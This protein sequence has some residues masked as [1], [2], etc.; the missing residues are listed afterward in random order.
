MKQDALY[1]PYIH[2]DVD[3]LK[4]SLLLFDRVAR[5]I[6]PQ[7]DSGPND[8]IRIAEFQE[9]GLLT[10]PNLEAERVLEAQR[11][12]AGKINA[13]SHDLAFRARYGVDAARMVRTDPLGFQIHRGKTMWE[14]QEALNKNG[15]AWIPDTYEAY[16]IHG[17]YIEVHPRVG[18]AVMSTIAIACALADGLHIVG[19]ARSGALHKTLLEKDLEHVYDAWLTE[20]APAP[21]AQVREEDVFDFLIGV[22]CDLTEV[23]PKALQALDREPLQD[24]MDQLREVIQRFPP[25]D[26]GS[27][28]DQVVSDAVSD[29]L[30]KWKGE[31]K[32]LGHYWKT[33]FGGGAGSPVTAFFKT[34]SDK[35][36]TTLTAGGIGG[37]SAAHAAL[38]SA[39][40]GIVVGAV[41]GLVVGIGTHGASSYK[42]MVDESKKSRYRYLTTLEETGVVFKSADG[43]RGDCRTSLRK[44]YR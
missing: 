33:F 38:A 15:L 7:E 30:K 21:P 24:L 32:N 36:I 4:G 26:P 6:P 42:T 8:D 39:L 37:W 22:H 17:D 1:Y 5:M 41:G 10:K 3:W 16:D 43:A 20:T 13:S 23:T 27:R 29:I 31:R 19:D 34:L 40:P 44:G 35:G 14:L 28:R 12:L 2:V 18:E 9:C 11:W 25:M